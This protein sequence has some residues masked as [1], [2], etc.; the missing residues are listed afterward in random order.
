MA[1]TLVIGRPFVLAVAN[2]PATYCGYAG[3][4]SPELQNSVSALEPYRYDTGLFQ[5]SLPADGGNLTIPTKQSLQLFQAGVGEQIVGG[6]WPKTTADTD[7]VRGGAPNDRPFMFLATG[8]CCEAPEPYQR[9]ASGTAETDPRFRSAWLAN[10]GDGPGYSL[11][12]QKA[13]INYTAI[14]FRF[15]D[16]GCS[17]RV[18]VAAFSPPWGGPAGAQ[19]VRNGLTSMPGVYLPFA[20]AVCIGPRDDTRQLAMTLTFGQSMTIQNNAA[21]PPTV[22]TGINQANS[23][24]VYAPVRVLVVGY[25]VCVPFADSCGILPPGVGAYGALPVNP[26]LVAMPQAPGL[27]GQVALPMGQGIPTPP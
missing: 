14:E 23:G 10:S 26:G 11:E 21:G 3:L 20:V 13:M 9:G 18:G 24:T 17:Y 4:C 2:Q 8:I 1:N 22:A 12:I 19:T 6:W 7:L 15:G 16:T 25:M 27:Q 5:W